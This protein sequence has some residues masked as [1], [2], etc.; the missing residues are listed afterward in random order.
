MNPEAQRIAI[1]EACGYRR[2][3]PNWNRWLK[4]D[5]QYEAYGIA[6]LPDY[7]SDLNAA[8]LLLGTDFDIRVR[9]AVFRVTIYEPSR[10]FE[11][12]SDNLCGA[13]CK[14]FLIKEEKWVEE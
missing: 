7:L 13:V 6:G 14:A 3:E 10:E 4:P 5:G 11:A 1:A 8:M 2:K 12:S 9:N